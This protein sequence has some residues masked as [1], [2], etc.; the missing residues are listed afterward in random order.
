MMVKLLKP[1]RG[2]M[3]ERISKRSL[4]LASLL[5]PLLVA[6]AS[7]PNREEVL[8]QGATGPV[9]PQIENAR[10]PYSERESERKL[11]HAAGG[12]DE[13]EHLEEFVKAEQA[14]TG[15]PLVAGNRVKLLIDGPATYNAMFEDVGNAKDNIHLETYTLADDKVGRQFADM[16]LERSSAGLKVKVI[17]DSIGSL[18]TSN[19]YFDRLRAGGVQVR[20]FRPVNPADVLH[21]WGVV[22]RDHRK[23]LILDGKVA[24]MGGVNI[25][26]V[27]SSGSSAE[28]EEDENTKSRWRDTEVR[29]EGPAVAELQKL[30]LHIWSQGEDGSNE[31]DG[32]DG[33]E[34]DFPPLHEIGRQLVRVIATSGEGEE[35]SIYKAYLVAISLAQERI[36]VTQAYFAPNDEFIDTLKE[37][38]M[39]GVDVRI[40][41]PGFSDHRMV[42]YAS[43]AHYTELLKAGVKLY[44][45]NDRLLHAKTAVIDGLWSTV[46][47][48]NMDYL[49]FLHNNEANVVIL[50]VD[51]GRQMEGL[52][53]SDLG[54]ADIIDL[55]VWEKRPFGERFME[56]FSSLFKYWF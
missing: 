4:Y 18:S 29:I 44:E 25:S 26:S 3:H 1:K 47:S 34:N 12:I 16:L 21:F 8:N 45:R 43:H 10:G 20:E 9:T 56:K 31:T 14:V 23:L 53:Q 19:E 49:S 15:R 27:Y 52:F 50:G 6:C 22:N 11:E 32:T 17:Y 48:S 41:L 33:T 5:L 40:I 24:F 54:H 46:G 7:L 13:A 28:R 39:R 42:L 55:K 38:A 37:A 30:F 36:W 2:V 51:F 35:Y